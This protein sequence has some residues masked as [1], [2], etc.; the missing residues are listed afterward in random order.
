MRTDF[1]IETVI[2]PAFE[3]NIAIMIA[4]IESNSGTSPTIIDGIQGAMVGTKE[5]NG[6][7]ALHFRLDE[8]YT[9][10]ELIDFLETGMGNP[11]P[12]ISAMS[13]RSALK[14]D[15]IDT[16]ETDPETGDPIMEMVYRVGIEAKKATFLKYMNDI[17]DGE[18][19]E[20]DPIMR[21]PNASDDLFLSG[22]FGTDPIQL[23]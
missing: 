14:I 20:G 2:N 8:E 17:Q 4:N 19:G 3:E 11:K 6:R 1:I 18:D 13:I 15:E 9:E 12:P 7:I 21:P 22:Y 10:V 23:V 16:G 5:A